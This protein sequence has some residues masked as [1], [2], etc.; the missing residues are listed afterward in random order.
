MSELTPTIEPEK[1]ETPV[2]L[3]VRQLQ[4]F[5]SGIAN[6]AF[7]KYYP[8]SAYYGGVGSK[9]QIYGHPCHAHLRSIEMDASVVF[10]HLPKVGSGEGEEE[11]YRWILGPDSPWH[12]AMKLGMSG[13]PKEF[14]S[15]SFWLKNGL[16]FDR[17]SIP[18]NLLHNFLCATRVPKEHTPVF[19]RWKS[20]VKKGLSPDMALIGLTIFGG[21]LYIDGQPNDS[22]R[23]PLIH[24]RGDWALDSGAYTERYVRNFLSHTPI[25]KR[26]I[27]PYS[28]SHQYTPSNAIWA[29]E[30]EKPIGGTVKGNWVYGLRKTYSKDFGELFNDAYAYDFTRVDNTEKSWRVNAEEFAEILRLEDKRLRA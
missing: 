26:M 22:V 24:A 30:G 13:T 2:S 10:N 4:E 12:S 29:D 7:G 28:K 1:G 9:L 27:H 5:A 17:L 23:T 25:E 15:E 21:G 11:Y 20:F 18:A 19:R 8:T 6:P 16:I 3:A 14:F